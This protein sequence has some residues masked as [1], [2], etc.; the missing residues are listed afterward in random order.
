M[1][2]PFIP[3]AEDRQAAKARREEA[4]AQKR[5]HDRRMIVAAGVSSIGLRCHEDMWAEIIHL[6]RRYNWR[7]P[8]PETVKQLPDAMIETQ[9]SGPNV[10]VMLDVMRQLSWSYGVARTTNA[11]ANRVY[12]AIAAIIDQVDPDNPGAPLPPA[13]LDDQA[14]RPAAETA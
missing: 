10:V 12:N 1:K 6:M 11:L 3:S 14:S 2:L 7:Q 13:I 9:L 4:Q 5:A 8:R